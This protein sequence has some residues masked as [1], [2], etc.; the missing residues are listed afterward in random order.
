MADIFISYA[1]EDRDRVQALAH[2]LEQKGWSVWWDRHIPIGRS[3]DEVIQEA[4]E[5]AKAVIVVWTKTSVK[6]QWVKNEAREGLSRRALF[7]VMLLEEVKIPL[8]FR[9]V[10]TAHL[11][12]WQPEEAHPAFDNFVNDMA[13]VLGRPPGTGVQ[14][15]PVKPPEEQPPSRTKPASEI[16]SEGRV[17]GPIVSPPPP[18]PQPYTFI[19]IGLLVAMGVFV[20]YWILKPDPP[21]FDPMM[22]EAPPTQRR[23]DTPFSV[24]ETAEKPLVAVPQEKPT[25]TQGTT[26]TK[27]TD[28]KPQPTAGPA[29][30]ITGTDGAPMLLIPAGAFWM[31]SPDGEGDKDEHPRHHVTLDAFYMDKFEVTVARYAEFMQANNRS[32]PDYWDQVDSSKHGNLPVVGVDWHDADAYCQWAGKRLPTEAEWEK[33][34]RG[35]DGRTY[36]WGN[37]QPTARLSNFGKTYTDKVYNNRLTPVDSYEVGKSP[38]GLRHMAGN[39]WEWVADWYDESYYGKSPDQ[40]PKGP[41]AGQ[42]RVLRG[43]SWGRGPVFVRSAGR[44]GGTPTA[45]GGDFGFRCAQDIPK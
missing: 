43:G 8:E 15:P 41:S 14:P 42:Y 35:T 22:V 37:E 9:H 34:A 5:A 12:D 2:A 33:A 32:K 25:T 10:Q 31:G 13:R 36:P 44:D 1:S 23:V 21:R 29:K 11:M 30:T 19:G 38:Y 40:N 45:R 3:F 17:S 27:A 20:A 7:P 4:I 39:V 16:E 6:S 26:G 24:P 18:Q 28:T